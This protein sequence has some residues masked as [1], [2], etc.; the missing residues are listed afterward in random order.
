[1]DIY[2]EIRPPPGFEHLFPVVEMPESRNYLV[3]INETDKSNQS[4][5]EDPD[6]SD[7]SLELPKGLPIPTDPAEYQRSINLMGGSDE[8]SSNDIE[9]DQSDNESENQN[10]SNDSKTTRPKS[11]KVKWSEDI[12]KRKIFVGNVPFNCTQEEFEECFADILGVYK[13]DIVKGHRDDSRGIGFVTMNSI[14]DAEDLKSR[15]DIKCKGRFL[16]FYPYQNNASKNS[17]ESVNNYIYIDGIPEDKDRKWLGDVFSDYGPF[18][19]Y[20]VAINHDTGERRSTGF[21][22][23]VDDYKY[24]KLLNNK[25]HVIGKRDD[26]TDR[27]ISINDSKGKSKRIKVE[28]KII[29]PE[30]SIILTTARYRQKT[31][32]KNKYRRSARKDQLLSAMIIEE[33]KGHARER[34]GKRFR[35]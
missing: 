13:A 1:M 18:H 26:G 17:M 33:H 7:H 16:R 8:E 21:L 14:A 30:N 6:D 32:I 24:E 12:N 19:R 28:P 35:R 11:E 31:I 22:D 9:I 34:S 5:G 20:F 2:N 10:S 3:R 27:A 25:Y 4:D 15:H 29:V 23:L